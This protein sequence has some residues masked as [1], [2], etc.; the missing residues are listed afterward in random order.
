MK[1]VLLEPAPAAASSSSSGAATPVKGGTRGSAD[2]PSAMEI[3][4]RAGGTAS[5]G[6]AAAAMATSPMLAP[7]EA[8]V[9]DGKWSTSPW[10]CC[11]YPCSSC[12]VMYCPCCVVDYLGK[13]LELTDTHNCCSFF[14][15]ACCASNPYTPFPYC[16]LCCDAPCGRLKVAPCYFNALVVKAQEKYNLP[17]PSPCGG[18]CL[19]CAESTKHPDVNKG[20]DCQIFFLGPCTICMLYRE[21][22]MRER[23]SK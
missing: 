16:N 18:V 6:A 19:V 12:F 3:Q 20:C 1:A 13:K 5:F 21:V 11:C 9:E 15:M 23:A 2:A 4:G 10:C 14:M 7:P 8:T 22:K 17:P